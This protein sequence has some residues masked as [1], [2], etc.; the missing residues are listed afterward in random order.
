MEGD[1]Q[2]EKVDHQ[3]DGRDRLR[4]KRAK[5]EKERMKGCDIRERMR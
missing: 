1:K 3:I 5:E 4:G 2:D